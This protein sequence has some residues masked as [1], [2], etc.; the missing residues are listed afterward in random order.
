MSKGGVVGCGHMGFR[1][2]G[3]VRGLV[4][5]LLVVRVFVCVMVLVVCSCWVAWGGW[6]AGFSEVSYCFV[7]LWG[8]AFLIAST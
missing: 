8:Y 6:V 5:A 4:H 2:Y 3:S 7:I 1:V